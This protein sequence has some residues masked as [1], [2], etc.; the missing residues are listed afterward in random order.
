MFVTVDV[1][2]GETETATLVPTS[3][4]WEDP[5]SGERGVYVVPGM[6]ELEV[7]PS[8]DLGTGAP[9]PQP[10]VF[11]RVSI[12][13][14]GRGTVGVAGVADGDWV[15]TVGHQMLSDDDD[16]VA[17][18]RPTAWDRVIELQNLQRE[19]V[20]KGFLDKQQR[21]MNAAADAPPPPSPPAA[22]AALST[23]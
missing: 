22:I 20:L 21:L 15:I 13:A 14:E 6:G 10:V 3:S 12:L 7:V 11:R 16:P 2:Y 18:V 4:I 19:D 1:F 23:D 5:L 8:G 17:V 9:K